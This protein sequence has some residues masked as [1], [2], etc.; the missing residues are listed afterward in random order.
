MGAA[1]IFLGFA[2]LFS[3]QVQGAF[4]AQTGNSGTALSAAQ[5][6]P[7]I[8]TAVTTSRTAPTTC[9]V[10][11]TPAAGLRA[12][13]TYDITDGASTL[14]TGVS[15][16]STTIT[17]PTTQLT[18]HVRIRYG[19]WTS[20]ATTTATT[21]C[22]GIPDPPVVTATPPTPRS[23]PP[24]PCPTTRARPSP[25]TPPPPAPHRPA[26]PSPSPPPAPAPSPASPT[27]SP[28]PSA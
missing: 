18:P 10:T 22:T 20:T 12:G 15:G 17:V 7:W 11:W 3:S 6:D 25:A 13:A 4:T 24:G 5:L 16:T 27:A 2:A 14:A 21:P 8:P 19:T 9:Q 23:P 1:L 26:A 28:T